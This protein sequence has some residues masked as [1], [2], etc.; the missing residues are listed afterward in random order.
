MREFWALL[1][2]EVTCY[3]LFQ[4]IIIFH[5]IHTT[6][7]THTKA[8]NVYLWYIVIHFIYVYIIMTWLMSIVSDRG[9]KEFV[10]VK[11]WKSHQQ[12]H[13]IIIL[14]S[15]YKIKGCIEGLIV[16]RK[17]ELSYSFFACRLYWRCVYCP[18]F[19]QWVRRARKKYHRNHQWLEKLD[20][21]RVPKLIRWQQFL[22]NVFV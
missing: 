20:E 6:F 11:I 8:H 18:L 3:R 7:C 17:S 12:S 2:F 5:R 1:H 15:L 22:Q 13:N 19:L 21:F 4:G 9:K 16:T 10:E 14:F